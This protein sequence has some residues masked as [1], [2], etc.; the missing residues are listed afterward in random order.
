M[1]KVDSI[2]VETNDRYLLTISS[3][4]KAN[5]IRNQLMLEFKPKV[6]IYV[7]KSLNK[8]FGWDIF[9]TDG[10]GC[11]PSDKHHESALKF[12]KKRLSAIN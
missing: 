8:K 5:K 4:E 1:V 7:V 6:C 12:A 2:G 9:I 10:I 3:L 11:Y